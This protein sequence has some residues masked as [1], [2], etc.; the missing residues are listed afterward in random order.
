LLNSFKQHT[1]LFS[2]WQQWEADGSL[3]ENNFSTNILR[4]ER[5]SSTSIV[6]GF[7]AEIQ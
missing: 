3:H 1:I 2:G 7:R 6:S 5:L 4:R